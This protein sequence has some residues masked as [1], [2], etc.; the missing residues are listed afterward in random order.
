[1]NSQIGSDSQNFSAFNK[2]RLSF[3]GDNSQNQVIDHS[4][5][6]FKSKNQNRNS[7]DSNE[8]KKSFDDPFAN[9][10]ELNKSNRNYYDDKNPNFWEGE[11]S[12]QNTGNIFETEFPKKN[13][14]SR[15]D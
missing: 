9:S 6:Q 13:S 3:G 5:S 7:L 11:A 2:D 12:K 1:M 4:T 14:Q 15:D 8:V 10:F